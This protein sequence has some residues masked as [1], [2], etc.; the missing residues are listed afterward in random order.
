LFITWASVLIANAPKALQQTKRVLK[1]DGGLIYVEHGRAPDPRVVAWQDRL[2]PVW[3]RV[4]GGCHLNRE[5]DEL[6]EGWIS[7]LLS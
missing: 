1:A 2:T 5:I 4:A 7:D 6:I 3:K